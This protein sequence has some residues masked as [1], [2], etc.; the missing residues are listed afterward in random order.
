M[1]VIRTSGVAALL[2]RRVQRLYQLIEAKKIPCP[3]RDTSGAY[4]W[5]PEQIEAARV[6]LAGGRPY[7]PRRG[8]AGSATTKKEET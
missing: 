4:Y 5:L 2:G 7:R 3:P 8:G 6:Y 1:V